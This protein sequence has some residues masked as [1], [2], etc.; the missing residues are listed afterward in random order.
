MI[1]PSPRT[2]MGFIFVLLSPVIKKA[3]VISG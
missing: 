1:H 2:E 3:E